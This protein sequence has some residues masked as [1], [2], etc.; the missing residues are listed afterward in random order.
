MWKI[1]IISIYD[2]LKNYEV[3]RIIEIVHKTGL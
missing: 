1:N 2:D 3:I